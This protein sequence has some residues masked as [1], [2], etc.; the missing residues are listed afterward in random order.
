MRT[1]I[2]SLFTAFGLIGGGVAVKEVT[3]TDEPG[4]ST[5]SETPNIDHNAAVHAAMLAYIGKNEIGD[6]DFVDQ[7]MREAARCAPRGNCWLG[8]NDPWC[9]GLAGRAVRDAGLEPPAEYY[10]ASAW[11]GWGAEQSAST[12]RRGDII[13][14][15]RSDGGYHVA[16]VDQV[17]IA[18]RPWLL[19]GGNQ[20][21]AVTI[22]PAP[23]RVVHIGRPTQES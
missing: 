13:V 1:W 21:N 19:L 14:T 5:A 16:V 9:G 6:R 11:I 18:P 2:T 20:S 4:H 10:R 7:I 17:P 23:G 22:A 3:K 15:R 12:A 8:G